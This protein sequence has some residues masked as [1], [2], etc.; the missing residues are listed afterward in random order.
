MNDDEPRAARILA[1]IGVAVVVVLIAATG[2]GAVG[3]YLQLS[4]ITWSF[5]L[6]GM[7]FLW[8]TAIGAVL[9]EIAG[10]NVSL[11]GV[12]R[13]TGGIRGVLHALV[14]LAVAA[15][16]MWSGWAM[17][18][19]TAFM[20]TPV[21]RAPA[22]IVQSSIPMMGLGLGIVAVWRLARLLRSFR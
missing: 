4:G 2:L 17:L 14:L 7:T 16:L 11:D 9:A 12:A 5:E 19:R 21:M 1:G 3:R 6:V 13:D 20:P 18:A 15:A 10:E 8:T 22:W